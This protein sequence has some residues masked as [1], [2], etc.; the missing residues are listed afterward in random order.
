MGRNPRDE[1]LTLMRC[2]SYIKPVKGGSLFVAEFANKEEIFC[3][4]S[5]S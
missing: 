5:L 3:F 2:H 4:S 1:P